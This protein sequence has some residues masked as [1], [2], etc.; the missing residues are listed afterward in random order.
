MGLLKTI[1]FNKVADLYDYYVNYDI[2][3]DF[4]VSE[5]LKVN[6]VVLELMSGTGR[7]SIPLLKKNVELHCVDYSK[8]MLAFFQKKLKKNHLQAEIYL[9]DVCELAIGKQFKLIMIPFNSFSEILEPKRHRQAFRKIKEHLAPDGQFI[10]TFHNPALK[11]KK[12]DGKINFNGMF[13]MPDYKS[14]LL[15]SVLNYNESKKIVSGYQ[16]YEIYNRYNK[17]IEKRYL[18]INFYLFTKDEIEELIHSTGFTINELYGDYS[19]S[20][21]D[22]SKSPYLIYK[23]KHKYTASIL[24]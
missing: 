17:M 1:Q 13:S 11:L 22:E 2:D 3:I 7:L 19:G 23:L 8:D 20:R 16:F 6:G 21:F 14:L 5:S 9:M 4:F 15:Y 12:I 24:N 10:C 18:E